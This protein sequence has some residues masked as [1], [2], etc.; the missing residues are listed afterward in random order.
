M[1]LY[2][3]QSSP[4]VGCRQMYIQ[5]QYLFTESYPYW[6]CFYFLRVSNWGPNLLCKAILHRHLICLTEISCGSAYK[7]LFSCK[8]VHISNQLQFELGHHSIWADWHLKTTNANPL[9]TSRGHHS[10]RVVTCSQNHILTWSKHKKMEEI[11]IPQLPWTTHIL[12]EKAQCT[13]TL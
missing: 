5:L 9:P 13:L 10:T 11:S 7:T 12:E 8:N 6:V 1:I 4:A 3:G 2:Y